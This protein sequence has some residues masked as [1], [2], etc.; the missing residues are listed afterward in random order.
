MISKQQDYLHENVIN[1]G[2]IDIRSSSFTR[3]FKYNSERTRLN[4]ITDWSDING[5]TIEYESEQ[6]TDEFLVYFQKHSD[7]VEIK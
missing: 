4:K 3:L 5:Y 1:Y 6:D 2:V 7:Y